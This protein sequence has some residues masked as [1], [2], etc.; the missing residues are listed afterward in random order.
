MRHGANEPIANAHYATAMGNYILMPQP[1]FEKTLVFIVMFLENSKNLVIFT[2]SS[3]K[4]VEFLNFIGFSKIF[5]HFLVFCYAFLTFLIFLECSRKFEK[6]KKV[7]KNTYK[8]RKM[9]ENPRKLKN[10]PNLL[11]LFVKITKCLDFS[12]KITIKTRVFS[13]SAISTA[14]TLVFPPDLNTNFPSI[15]KTTITL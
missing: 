5:I 12:K 2:K 8:S 13:N 15:A 7:K 10:S 11:L 4:F 3:N 9:L 6:I 1:E 14:A